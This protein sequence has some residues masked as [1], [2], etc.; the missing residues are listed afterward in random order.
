[1][2]QIVIIK[3]R[4]YYRIFIFDSVDWFVTLCLHIYVLIA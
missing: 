2:E 4:S 1:M 3:E